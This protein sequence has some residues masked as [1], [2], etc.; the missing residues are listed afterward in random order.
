[1]SSASREISQRN[2]LPSSRLL[3][4]LNYRNRTS[5]VHAPYG[6]GR[7]VLALTQHLS[8]RTFT[9]EATPGQEAILLH[10]ALWELNRQIEAVTIVRETMLR[11]VQ[12]LQQTLAAHRSAFRRIPNEILL[13]IFSYVVDQPP[14]PFAPSTLCCVCREWHK[15]VLN[16]RELWTRITFELPNRRSRSDPYFDMIS[17]ARAYL[18]R[19]D[20]LPVSVY[21][22]SQLQQPNADEVAL[23]LSILSNNFGRCAKLY[24]F[25]DTLEPMYATL[26]ALT[27][28]PPATLLDTLSLTVGHHKPERLEYIAVD[29]RTEPYAFFSGHAPK[30]KHVELNGIAVPWQGPAAALTGLEELRLAKQPREERPS[31]QEFLQLLKAS[32]NLERLWIFRSGPRW[33]DGECEDVQLCQLT[34][35][36]LVD[37]APEITECVMPYIAMPCLEALQLSFYDHRSGQRLNSSAVLKTLSGTKNW[38]LKSLR[39]ENAMFRTTALVSFLIERGKDL[40]EIYLYSTSADDQLLDILTPSANTVCPQLMSLTLERCDDVS[41]CG[42]RIFWKQRKEGGVLQ[43]LHVVNCGGLNLTYG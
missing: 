13:H 31:L 6:Q 43:R 14:D 26:D 29:R 37:V 36:R 16:A 15:L 20:P 19:S 9:T 17:T 1:M 42:L 3:E 32:P 41:D 39:L 8:P 25:Y 12:L 7:S 30:L 28:F 11:E 40:R 24:V 23:P 4:I 21:I 33:G 27:R 10:D 5:P 35:L 2:A 18:T 22:V 34:V 38:L